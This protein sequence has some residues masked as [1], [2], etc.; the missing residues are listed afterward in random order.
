MKNRPFSIGPIYRTGDY[1]QYYF[2]MVNINSGKKA[3]ELFQQ[4]DCQD[5]KPVMD[6]IIDIK[7][8]NKAKYK[9]IWVLKEANSEKGGW[10]L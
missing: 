5:V 4:I 7:Q 8:Y 6:G 1:I 2:N 9:I 10:D 3:D